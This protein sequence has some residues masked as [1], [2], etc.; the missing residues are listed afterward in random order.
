[1]L[2]KKEFYKD[3]NEEKGNRRDETDCRERGTEWDRVKERKK[4]QPKED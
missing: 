4:D 1:M 2:I 3:E